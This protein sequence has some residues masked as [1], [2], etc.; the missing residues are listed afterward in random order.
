M[1]NSV[2]FNE[3]LL[4]LLLGIALFIGVFDVG[5]RASGYVFPLL[6]ALIAIG[7]LT[8]AMLLGASMYEVATVLMV[9][10][11]VNLLS[12]GVK[13]EHAEPKVDKAEKSENKSSKNE[14]QGGLL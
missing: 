13:A 3:P 8:Y 1:E 2:I 9:F 12:F 6:S 10:V 4:L 11:A 7:T 5:K 14:E